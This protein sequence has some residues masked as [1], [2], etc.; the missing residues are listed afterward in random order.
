MQTPSTDTQWLTLGCFNF[1]YTFLIFPCFFQTACIIFPSFHFVTD[2]VS[3]C[4][5]KYRK[6]VQWKVYVLLILAPSLWGD[7]SYRFLVCPPRDVFGG[8]LLLWQ[9]QA[10]TQKRVSWCGN[11]RGIWFTVWVGLNKYEIINTLPTHSPHGGLI[12]I[13]TAGQRVREAALP[14]QRTGDGQA[15]PSWFWFSF[16][17][18]SCFPLGAVMTQE[19]GRCSKMALSAV[20]NSEGHGFLAFMYSHRG[21]VCTAVKA[22]AGAKYKKRPWAQEAP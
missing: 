12:R 21:Q 17:S 6:A 14:K 7:L 9:K 13:A 16:L 5:K 8:V 2:N 19:V 3:E 22:R 1:F 18:L 11:W 20:L 4:L 15:H 10:I